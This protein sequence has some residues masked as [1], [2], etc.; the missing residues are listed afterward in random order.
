MFIQAIHPFGVCATQ[1]EFYILQRFNGHLLYPGLS[2]LPSVNVSSTYRK[3]PSESQILIYLPSYFNTGSL[4]FLYHNAVVLKC[5][6]KG[7]ESIFLVVYL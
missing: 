2:I 4:Y 5:F 7:N 3:M 6:L 1:H